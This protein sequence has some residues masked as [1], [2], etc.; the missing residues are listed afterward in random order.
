MFINLMDSGLREFSLNNSILKTGSHI[1]QLK[2]LEYL[3][4]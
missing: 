1:P 3:T 2:N 4:A